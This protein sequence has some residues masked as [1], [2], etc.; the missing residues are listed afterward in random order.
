MTYHKLKNDVRLSAAL[1]GKTPK[2]II[3][4]LTAHIQ[5]RVAHEENIVA[6]INPS[7]P[8]LPPPQHQNF[9]KLDVPLPAQNP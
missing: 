9:Q 1:T 2:Q 3:Q 8:L 6:T 5:A 4:A 7:F